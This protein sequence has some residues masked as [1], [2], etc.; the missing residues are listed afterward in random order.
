MLVRP[1]FAR[2]FGMVAYTEATL[3]KQRPTLI[4]RN[5]ANWLE[6]ATGSVKRNANDSCVAGRFNREAF[7]QRIETMRQRFPLSVILLAKLPALETT[8]KRSFPVWQF[9]LVETANHNAGDCTLE[10]CEKC[11]AAYRRERT[12][13]LASLAA[14]KPIIAEL[15]G[16]ALDDR[17]EDVDTSHIEFTQKRPTPA[18]ES[19]ATTRQR[20]LAKMVGHISGFRPSASVQ[21]RTQRDIAGNGEFAKAYRATQ[22]FAQRKQ[23]ATMVVSGLIGYRPETLSANAGERNAARLAELARKFHRVYPATRERWPA[24][25]TDKQKARIARRYS[26]RPLVWLHMRRSAWFAN[27]R[28]ACQLYAFDSDGRQPI[29]ESLIR[30]GRTIL[31]WQPVDTL[32]L[33]DERLDFWRERHSQNPLAAGNLNYFCNS[34]RK[35][36]RLLAIRHDE[37]ERVRS[38]GLIHTTGDMSDAGRCLANVIG[39]RQKYLES[40]QRP[41]TMAITA[42]MVAAGWKAIAEV[43]HNDARQIRQIE[44]ALNTPTRARNHSFTETCQRESG[45]SRATFHRRL[46]KARR[47]VRQL[48]E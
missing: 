39:Q 24:K 1:R 47:L 18:T 30:A 31:D 38:G 12:Y 9:E 2:E 41:D 10:N 35:R 46:Q 13:T 7:A 32:A 22:L 26:Q 29:I 14:W 34:L 3:P 20:L 11:R 21:Q 44:A 40:A 28:L 45:L 27:A 4:R 36:M 37:R 48:A 16:K 8:P 33:T 25:L 5:A 43:C 23:R 15:S 6:L 19:V 42:E 17:P